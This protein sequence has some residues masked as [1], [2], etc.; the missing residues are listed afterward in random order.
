MDK[1]ALVVSFRELEGLSNILLLCITAIETLGFEQWLTVRRPT[2]FMRLRVLQRGGF[3]V[4][5]PGFGCHAPRCKRRLRGVHS[6][7]V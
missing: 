7:R 5:Q 2:C 4:K 1:L 6:T 3:R